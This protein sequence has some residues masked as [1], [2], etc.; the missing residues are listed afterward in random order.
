MTNELIE[1]LSI[2]GNTL[3]ISK[4]KLIFRPAA[5]AVIIHENKI[6][7]TTVKSNGQLFFPGGGVNLGETTERA[8]KREV[9][10]EVG[11]EINIQSFLHFHDHFFYYD[12]TDEAF[13][14]LSFYYRCEP[15]TFNILNEDKI[16]D[17]EATKPQWYDLEDLRSG[18]ENMSEI[19]KQIIQLI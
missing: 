13:H 11:I 5:Y 4:E 14:S 8:L 3:K 15:K 12:P 9:H 10:E 19:V 17:D 1:C 18:K 2:K 16:E 7:M 6:L